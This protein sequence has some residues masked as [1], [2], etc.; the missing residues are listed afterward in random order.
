[1]KKIDLHIH[2]VSSGS[3]PAF[4]FSIEKLKSYINNLKLDCIAITNHNIFDF[5]NYRVIQKSIDIVVLPGVEVDI[6]DSHILV[7]ASDDII[8]DFKNEC[9]ALCNIMAGRKSVSFEEFIQ[10]FSNYRKYLIIPHYKKYPSI[11]SA[12]LSKFGDNIF[13][14]E[15]SSAK[16]WF[17]TIK[18]ENEL[19]PVIFSDSRIADTLE[20]Y[21]T[22][23][24]YI[25]CDSITLGSLKI[26][27]RNRKNLAITESQTENEFV[28]LPDGT[29]GSTG[30]NVIVGKRSSGKTYILKTIKSAYNT[31]DV[32]YIEQF[33]IVKLAEE[34]EFSKLITSYSSKFLDRYLKE[35]KDTIEKVIEIDYLADMKK[36]D[37]YLISLKDYAE[38][39]SNQ[40]IYS[41]CKLFNSQ[42]FERK[43]MSEINSLI[44][45]VSTLLS[46]KSYKKIIEEHVSISSLKSLLINL[47][48]I[49]KTEE[50]ENEIIDF[51]NKAIKQIKT[52]LA[53]SSALTPVDDINFVSIAEDFCSIDEFNVKCNRSKSQKIVLHDD[54]YR[55][56]LTATRKPFLNITSVKS[57]IG[58]QKLTM[59]EAF[60][61]YGVPYNYIKELSKL[62][63][64]SDVISNAIF[65]IEFKT[66]NKNGNSISGGERAEYVLFSEL[67]DASKFEIVLIDEPE[68]SF[69]NL[70]LRD[71]IRQLIK[72][73]A[74]KTTVFLVTHNHTLG[75]L[76]DPDKIIYT[77]ESNGDYSVYTGSL[78]S[79]AFKSTS[80]KEIGSYKTLMDTM[81][82]GIS[83][84]KERGDIYENLRDIK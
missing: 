15:V 52:I 73:L 82:A 36:L 61:C 60:A 7:I 6:E 27:L 70:F 80:G 74:Q 17:S 57:R 68:S 33:S 9:L 78:T 76:L 79:S 24:T 46:S 1:M 51:S 49:G 14:G 5:E 55:F 40:D 3:E 48:E 28:F 58:Y 71:N 65:D 75:I 45:S 8:D 11:S 42:L 64:S 83:S 81:E 23:L 56:T 66:L 20:T 31:Q 35:L 38:K 29:V 69:D 13:V 21:P 16:K 34:N 4:I 32:K 25:N 50:L 54:M 2:T 22:N 12:L 30:L 19:I 44:S 63:L 59:Q 77:E 26:A 10:I 53:Q 39:S 62:G 47:I 43:D 18:K 84:Y 41:K 37:D 67:Y 72:N